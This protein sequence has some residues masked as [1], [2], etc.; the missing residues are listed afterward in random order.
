MRQI[1]NLDKETMAMASGAGIGVIQTVVFK[2][3]IDP[4]YGPFPWISGIIPAP[5]NRWST[6]GNILIGGIIFGLTSF[7]SL[8]SNKSFIANR[9]LQIYGI[10]TLIGGITN[11][12]FPGAVAGARAP[13]LRATRA[14]A[15]QRLGAGQL[16]PTG[17]PMNKILA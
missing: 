17:I 12:I 9:F 4:T 7:T 5:W 10:T 15:A 1:G 6:F 2:E 13:A 11:G 16:T 3:Y 14:V 8:I